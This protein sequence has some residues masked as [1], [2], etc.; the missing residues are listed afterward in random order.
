MKKLIE[1]ETV[2]RS[3]K[4]RGLIVALFVVVT[5]L[6][7]GQVLI[8][9]RLVGVADQL[10]VLDRHIQEASRRTDKLSYELRQQDSLST[11]AVQAA[12]LGFVKTKRI[13]FLETGN[14]PMAFGSTILVR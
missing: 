7:I 6:L 11:I 10:R 13:T 8:A 4:S 3:H 5:V 2:K 1:E 14:K 9:N 12:S